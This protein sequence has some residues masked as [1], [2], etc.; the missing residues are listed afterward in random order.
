VSRAQPGG[1][2]DAVEWQ[3]GI[4]MRV[5]AYAEGWVRRAPL[6]RPLLLAI[7]GTITVGL[8]PA[9]AFDG[10]STNTPEKIPLK[11]FANAQ[12]ALRAGIDD[13][14]AGDAQSSVEALTYAADGGQAI[15]LEAWRDVR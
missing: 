8:A 4:E 6:R 3:V 12:Q 10:S 1:Y 15:T 9:L 13:L 5:F 11:S 7:V 14:K 2:R